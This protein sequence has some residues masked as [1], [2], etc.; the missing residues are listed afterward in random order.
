MVAVLK[1]DPIIRDM[2]I[3]DLPQVLEFERQSYPFPWTFG[4]FEDCLRVGYHCQVMELNEQLCAYSVY[5]VAVGDCHLLN[6]CIGPPFRRQGLARFM[7][8]SILQHSLTL[9]AKQIFLEVR[10]SNQ[11]AITL[12]ES[13]QFTRLARRPDYYPAID[14]REDAL[15][16][17]RPIRRN[18]Y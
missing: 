17:I 6:I 16:L 9:G 5:S 12:Y 3:E 7:I 8:N 13:M 14:G 15:V 1:S 4:I 11:A 2:S 10:P 18:D